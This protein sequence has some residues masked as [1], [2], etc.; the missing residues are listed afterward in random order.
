M[1]LSIS[2][3]CSDCSQLF[4]VNKYHWESHIKIKYRCKFDYTYLKSEK[5]NT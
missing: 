1:D 4:K 2:N 3:E 5:K